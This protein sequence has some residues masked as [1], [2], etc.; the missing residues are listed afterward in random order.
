MASFMKYFE[1]AAFFTASIAAA[2]QHRD[3]EESPSTAAP[4]KVV[5][6]TC[7][8]AATL[9]RKLVLLASKGDYAG[10]VDPKA[11]GIRPRDVGGAAEEEGGE[12]VVA[13]DNSGERAE[14][15]GKGEGGEEKA[16]SAAAAAA[17]ALSS[18]QF[19]GVAAGGAQQDGSGTPTRAERT[20][21]RKK[22]EFKASLLADVRKDMERFRNGVPG[23][24]ISDVHER[25][26]ALQV[27]FGG[28]EGFSR[29]ANLRA[30]HLTTTT[31]TTTTT[32]VPVLRRR[33]RR[34][35]C[36]HH[37][38]PRQRPRLLSP[39]VLPQVAPPL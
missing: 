13:A 26:K 37:A 36:G 17:S 24:S 8:N 30:T 32:D 20:K 16:S 11:H 39:R 23:V 31:T 21:M 18:F 34:L 9:T 14:A 25:A 3:F 6:V 12:D 10:L 27:G 28:R 4:R 29:Q 19:A 38:R 22:R 2:M 35:L 1:A 33:T 15:E 7:E 5:S